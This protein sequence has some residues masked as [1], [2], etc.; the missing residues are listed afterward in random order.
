MAVECDYDNVNDL[1]PENVFPA[2]DNMVIEF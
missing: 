1:T 2:F